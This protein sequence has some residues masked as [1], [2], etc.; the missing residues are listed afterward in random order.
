MRGGNP[1]HTRRKPRLDLHAA[2]I[3]LAM[4]AGLRL[5]TPPAARA[6]HA[7]EALDRQRAVAAIMKLD[8]TEKVSEQAARRF[9]REHPIVFDWLLQ[10]SEKAVVKRLDGRS[11]PIVTTAMIERTLR[12][13]GHTAAA[14]RRRFAKLRASDVQ[15]G[16]RRWVELYLTACER[17]RAL[18]LEPLLTRWRRIVFTKHYNLGGSHYAYT[19]GQ[20]DAQNERHFTP[21][22]ALCLLE[23]DGLTASVRTLIDD[24]NGVIRDPAVSYDGKRILFAWKK[25]DR[26]DDYHLYDMDVAA[27]EVRRLT[28][29]LGYADYEPAYL[30]NGDIVFSSTR[31]VQTVD[32]WWTEVSNLYTCDADG[33]FLRRLGFDQVHTNF[34]TVLDDGRVIYTRWEYSDRGQIYVQGLFQMNPDGTG[35]IAYY[36][37]NSWFPT[38]LLHARGI[39]GTRKVVAV[40]S[41]HHTRQ[42]GKLVIVDTDRG[43]EE[44]SGVQLIA[45]VRQTEAVRVDRYGQDGEQFQYPYPL[46]ETEFLVTY[47]PFG[48][49]RQPLL[50]K[51]YLMTIDGRRELLVADGKNS[52]NQPVPLASRPVPHRRPDMAEH[53]ADSGLYFVQD[54]YLGQGL[55]G[56]PRGT[57]KRLRVV[58]IEYRAAGVGSN[59]NRGPAGGALI[60]TPIAIDNG[61]WDVKTVLGDAT[62]HEDGS[63]CFAVPARTPVYFQAL[64]ANG[65][66][67]QTMRSWS[68]LQPGER[69][70]CV[71]CHETKSTVPPPVERVPMAMRSGP[72]E[73]EPFYGPPRGFSFPREIQPIL[74]RHCVRCHRQRVRTVVAQARPAA[75]HQ[76]T[77]DPVAAL[78]DG[79]EPASSEDRG[80]PR[81]T[82]WP[83]KGTREWVQY[84]LP[85]P[86]LMK[87]V[88]VFW[89]DD[90]RSGGRC[91]V[92]A[93]WRVLVRTDKGWRQVADRRRCGIHRDRYNVVAF[94]PIKTI[95]IRLDVQLAS[96]YS[97]GILEWTFDSAEAEPVQKEAQP[98]AFSLLGVQSVDR[99][100]QRMWSDAYLALTQRGRPNR[101][102]HWISAQS[103]PT[104]LPP[105]HAGAARSGLIAMLNEGHHGV[106]LSKEE[107]DKIA[108]WIDLL[109]PYCGDY[110]EACAWTEAGRA[111][112]DHFEAKRKRMAA[113]ERTNI[114]ALLAERRTSR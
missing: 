113:E 70:S 99:R 114:Q 49:A 37:N 21:G 68:T 29:G 101:R 35:Q 44:A 64:D 2:V 32:C 58:A 63:A 67:V 105:Y 26:T 17:R 111:K 22:T 54:V 80:I 45:P 69:F 3:L 74:D 7:T 89:F 36:G 11:G 52:C 91:R 112:Y 78:N 71:G 81:F 14:L 24:P 13:L 107:M 40:A 46:S 12:E 18:R 102:V 103:V 31:C 43:H 82:W 73:L 23:L 60:S 10:D 9:E 96:G 106:A 93:S 83:H 55:Q 19:E 109:V 77:S 59:R 41:G 79:K 28:S 47:D 16:D 75:S 30:P 88:S 20:S 65:H 15:P 25:A 39:P 57:I 84:D 108:C 56:V 34:P 5:A 62:V 76:H 94:E 1:T 33:R 97:C 27:G 110:T 87:G 92:P 51:I 53:Q 8:I 6:A 104:V 38:T 72:Q 61:A 98:P 4:A 50:F 86:R 66:A 85:E 90:T 48:Y 100:A 42:T 95:G